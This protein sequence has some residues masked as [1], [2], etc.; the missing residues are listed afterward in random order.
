[1]KKYA[2][3]LSHWK[4]A[5]GDLGELLPVSCVEVLPGDVFRGNSTLFLRM[6]PLAAP[7]MH[8]VSV[9]VHHFYGA[10]RM[11]WEEAGG[12]GTWEDFITGGNSGN[13]AQTVPTIT[14]T[15][16]IGDLLDYLGIADT[17][18]VEVNALPVAMFNR[19]FNEWY[20]DQDLVTARV[21]NDLT[22][23][24][25]AWGKDYLTS[26]RPW[27][28]RGD[29]ISLP[30]GDQARIATDA[31][32]GADVTV[33][34]TAD[35]DTRHLNSGGTLLARHA[36]SG[37]SDTTN[38][39]YAD[40]SNATASTVRDLRLA[41]ALQRYAEIRARFGARYPEFLSWYGEHNVDG[42]LQIPEYLGGGSSQVN[43]S[44]VM[45]TAPDTTE[46]DF[47]VGDLY[48]HGVAAMRSNNYKRR[49]P[50]HGYVMTFVSVRP[51]SMYMDGIPRWALRQDRED[52]FDPT[53]QNIGEQAVY[54]NEVFADA[55]DG[56]TVFG[57]QGRYDDYR[58]CMSS[59]SGEFRSVLDYWHLGRTFATDPALNETFVTCDP[60]KRVFNEQT[61][62][63]MW[64]RVR[65]N[66][67]AL[68]PVM[69]RATTRT[70]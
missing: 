13:D 26:A 56:D 15:G 21:W 7:V 14:S 41:F 35:S 18:G 63:S 29:A 64:M 28:Q 49:F 65:N 43:F 39:L 6:S 42:R 27:P 66:I 55:V 31:A 52:F 34:S 47:S 67:S 1:M 3:N 19:V 69:S 22:I 2:H 40:L 9:R 38:Q 48:G 54:K 59:V 24:K 10:S 17:A 16:T 58:H 46:R 11:F 57:Y 32:D 4:L 53:L 30:L 60:T 36:S 8:P 61:Q 68:R 70:L 51:V 5:T 23:P 33:Y 37:G 62:H 44:E 50:E 12:T 25:V 20:A 45:Q